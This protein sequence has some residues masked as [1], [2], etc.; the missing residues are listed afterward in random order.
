MA[1]Q[2]TENFEGRPIVDIVQSGMMNYFVSSNP[3]GTLGKAVC[4]DS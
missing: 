4:N 3:Q 1:S 2:P